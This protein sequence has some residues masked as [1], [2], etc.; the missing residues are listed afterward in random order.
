MQGEFVAGMI[1]CL[2]E[3]ILGEQCPWN[4][5]VWENKVKGESLPIEIWGTHEKG[6]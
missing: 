5:N 2:G 3:I 1:L 4:I 6:E